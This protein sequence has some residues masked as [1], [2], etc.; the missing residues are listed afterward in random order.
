VQSFSG[1]ALQ[2]EKSP[3]ANNQPVIIISRESFVIYFARGSLSGGGRKKKNLQII[4]LVF[5]K[6]RE[7]V[8]NAC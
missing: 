6:D 3:L 2:H 7:N 5:T 4:Q 8:H 1:I